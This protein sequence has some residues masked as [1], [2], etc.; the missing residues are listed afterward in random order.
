M[1]WSQLNQAFPPKDWD[2]P[3]RFGWWT[4][5]VAGK[6]SIRSDSDISFLR[7]PP[8]SVS[9]SLQEPASSG[10]ALEIFS[11]PPLSPHWCLAEPP[12]GWTRAAVFTLPSSGRLTTTTRSRSIAGTPTQTPK[13]NYS[14]SSRKVLP[15]KLG[16]WLIFL[17]FFYTW[18][19]SQFIVSYKKSC[20]H[21]YKR[22]LAFIL[23]EKSENWTW[24]GNW[25]SWMRE[26]N[27]SLL[28]LASQLLWAD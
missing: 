27:W 8:Q 23:R 1:C 5:T 7:C 12:Y 16:W 14:N 25:P 20:V 24:A 2:P 9:Y 15:N 22:A 28:S 17:L 18:L 26:D 4:G 19:F 3:E 13:A 21:G 10:E 6:S 11:S